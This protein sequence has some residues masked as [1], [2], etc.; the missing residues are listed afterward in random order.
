M[1]TRVCAL[2][3][4]LLFE[5]L[6]DKVLVVANEVVVEALGLKVVTKVFPPQGIKSIQS[7]KLGRGLVVSVHSIGAS[8]SH[9]ACWRSGARRLGRGGRRRRVLMS[10][11]QT[12]KKTMVLVV[13]CLG[14]A[15]E[16]CLAGSLAGVLFPIVH[17]LQELLGLLLVYERQAGQT[18]LELEGVEEDAVLVVAPG[19]EDLLVPDHSSVSG[20]NIN[21]LYPVC[22]SHKIV[23]Q[24]DGTLKAGIRPFRG[25]WVGYIEPGDG[26]GMDLVGLFGH[27]ALDRLLVIVGKDGRHFEEI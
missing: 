5:E 26:D 19:V 20:R 3:R 9:T 1:S 14:C 24:H 18:L 23:C 2:F 16:W 21:H 8:S 11:K 4:L 6:D 7:R 10:S 27:A 12:S 22:V 25:V 17:L 15:S 13:V